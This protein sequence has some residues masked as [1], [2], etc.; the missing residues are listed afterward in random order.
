MAIL[1]LL[2]LFAEFEAEA[3]VAAAVD[4]LLASPAKDVGVE[5]A[6]PQP[7]SA[8]T[9]SV[10]R[11]RLSTLLSKVHRE[12]SDHDATRVNT[13]VIEAASL[14]AVSVF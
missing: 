8:A 14:L 1:L 13:P 9:L 5:S 3:E 4:Q 10:A 12:D 7:Q 6:P 11:N 2:L